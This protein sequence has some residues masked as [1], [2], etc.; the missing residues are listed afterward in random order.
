MTRI[1]SFRTHAERN[2]DS[3]SRHFHKL[4]GVLVIA[5]KGSI[6]N[7][8]IAAD[9]IPREVSRAAFSVGASRSSSPPINVPARDGNA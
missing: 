6:N 4:L 2:C 3:T 7:V 5:A 8:I 9:S 1:D